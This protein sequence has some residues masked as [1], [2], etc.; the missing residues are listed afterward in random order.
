MVVD[1]EDI[2]EVLSRFQED[3]TAS[4]DCDEGWYHLIVACHRELER[5]DP[6]YTIFQIKEK[7]GELRYYATPSNPELNEMFNAI[8]DKYMRISRQTC[9]VSGKHGQLM[10]TKSGWYKTLH[11]DHLPDGNQ[12][13]TAEIVH[14]E[15][16]QPEIPD[17]DL[18]GLS[19]EGTLRLM[20]LMLVEGHDKVVVNLAPEFLLEAADTITELREQVSALEAEVEADT[21]LRK[22]DGA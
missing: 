21:H 9:E 14:I 19:V 1:H 3:Y 5:L 17:F 6:N 7:F 2:K 16:Q 10:R 18:G 22:M 11:K 15:P 20:A 8:V 13:T 4:I 12:W